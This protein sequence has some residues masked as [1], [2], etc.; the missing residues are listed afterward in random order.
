MSPTDRNSALTVVVI[1][2]DLLG[3]YGDGGNG[4]ILAR[5]ASWRGIDAELVQAD[6]GRPLPSADIYCIGGGEDAPQVRAAEALRADRTFSRAVEQG[7]VVLGVCAGYQ[8]LGRSFPDG[9]GR[10]HDGLGFLD[11]S[12]TKGRGTRAVGE[13]LASVTADA[14][15]LPT[16]RPLPMLTGF[17]NHGGR[18]AVGGGSGAVARVVRGVGNGVGDHTE[19]AWSDRV[20]GTYLHGP[21]LA[22]NVALADLLVGWALSAP[23]SAPVALEPLD[24][25]DEEALRRERLAAVGPDRPSCPLRRLRARRSGRG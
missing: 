25:G 4:V 5:R 10:P 1:Y 19:G 18:T 22:R 9:A 17:E 21:V 3:T 2:P 6:S 12:T 23:G 20:F 11:V 16:G 14:P 7:A 15:R 24:D 8:L 13:L